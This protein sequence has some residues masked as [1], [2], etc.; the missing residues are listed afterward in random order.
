MHAIEYSYTP[1][2]FSNIWT[3]NERREVGYELRN[4]NEYIIPNHRIELFKRIPL[5][6]LPTEWNSAGDIIFHKNKILFRNLLK[7]KLLSDI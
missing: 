4:Q 7:E 1:E 2:S 3:K 6:S 5:F